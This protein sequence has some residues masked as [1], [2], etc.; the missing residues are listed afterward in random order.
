VNR[1][2]K[3]PDIENSSY[4]ETYVVGKSLSIVKGFKFTGVDPA[5]GVPQFLDVN[6]DGAISDP[7]DYVDLG[8]TLPKFYGGLGNSITY[9]HWSL[10]ILFQFVKQEGPT[11]DYG[12][13]ANSYGTMYNQDLSAL[14]RWQQSGDITNI[15]A[16]SLTSG[17][18]VYDAFRNQ[19]RLSSAVWGDASYIRLKNV[20]LNYDL[21]PY[22][23]KW[24]V[25]GL[26]VYALAQNLVTIT[27]YRGFDPETQGMVVPPLK[28]ITAGVKLSF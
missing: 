3:Y 13:Q 27:H 26:S 23:R 1:L 20:A 17:N 11:V 28:T 12:Y 9:K 6:K 16:A 24:K 21:S 10:D 22:V 19:Y 5:T 4:S 2:Q 15:P 25:S 7:D 18:P 14:H 8:Q